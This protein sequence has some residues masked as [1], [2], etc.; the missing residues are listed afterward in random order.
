MVEYEIRKNCEGRFQAYLEEAMEIKKEDFSDG[1]IGRFEALCYILTDMLKD[2]MS[3]SLTLTNQIKSILLKATDDNLD[4]F[5]KQLNQGLRTR[6]ET[7]H[8]SLVAVCNLDSKTLDKKSFEVNKA[9]M[10]LLNFSE[11]EARFG[12]SHR[13]KEWNIFEPRRASSFIHYSYLVVEVLSDSAEDAFEKANAE[14]ELFRGLLNFAHFCRMSH[15]TQYGGIPE[16]RTLSILQPP[17]VLMLFNEKKEH[18]NDRFSIGFYDYSINQFKKERMKLLM[19]LIKRVNS[20]KEC[21]L[22][23]R[24]MSSFRKY[25][26]GLDGNVAGTSFME[27]WKILELVALS[28]KEERMPEA[29]VAN[30]ISS[31]FKDEFSR[32]A[33]NALCDKRNFIAHVGSLPEFD[34]NEINLLRHYCEQ[35]IL[36]LLAY[37]NV[38]EDEAT[39]ACFYDNKSKSEKDLQRLRKA[40]SEILRERR[41]KREQKS[42]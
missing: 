35:A 26:N 17:K 5:L 27:F 30:R 24:C 8:F 14:F 6:G 32:D 38:F 22:K 19:D 10:S 4:S 3:R 15:Y 13:F 28:D 20:S 33:L 1:R 42:G 31:L 7:Q 21:S 34:Q 41:A 37:T 29:R 25:N 18:I 11:A 40:I 23:E 16:P 39:L 9:K 12:I 36:F 2:G